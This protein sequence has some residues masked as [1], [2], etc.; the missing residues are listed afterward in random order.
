MKPLLPL[1]LLLI[2]SIAAGQSLPP[3]LADLGLREY[4][5]PSQALRGWSKPQRVVV[6]S[7]FGGEAIARLQKAFPDVEI[8]P[9]TTVAEAVAAIPGAQVLVGFCNQAIFDA[10]D[11]LRW[12]Q[13]YFAGVE[14][15]V[16]TPTMAAGE[17]VLTNGQRLGQPDPGGSCNSTDDVT[18]SRP[19]LGIRI[20]GS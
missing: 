14:N 16:T 17:L 7:I 19:G 4:A 2:S 5:E 13:S 3:P 8:V 11:E 20:P 9:V 1:L 6:R 12:V 10:A 15:C 18:D